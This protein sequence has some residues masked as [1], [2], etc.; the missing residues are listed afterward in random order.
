MK[1]SSYKHSILSDSQV[2][3]ITKEVKFLKLLSE[4]DYQFY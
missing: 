4:R 3:P 2:K 1:K